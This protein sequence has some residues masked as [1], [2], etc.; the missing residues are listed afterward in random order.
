MPDHSASISDLVRNFRT[1][2][3]AYKSKETKEAEIRQQFIDPFWRALGW[4]VGDSKGVG[5]TESEVIIEKNVETIDAGGLRSRRPDYLFRL[6][7]FARF[8]VETKKPFIDIDDDR[9]AIFQAKQ[10]AW[11][12][13]IP[14]AI[15]TNF[16]EFRLYDTTLKPIFNDQQRGLVKEVVLDYDKY[17]LQWDAIPTAFAQQLTAP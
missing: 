15:L 8:I 12:S 11:N 14:F 6:G 9:D 5:P 13:T 10:Y 16:E 2:I 1:H 4:D 3:K 17:E 7:G